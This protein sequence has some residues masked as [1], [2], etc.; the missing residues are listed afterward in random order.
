M[1]HVR[2]YKVF[3]DIGKFSTVPDGFKNICVHMVYDVKHDGRHRARLVANGQL[4]DISIDSVHS[5]EYRKL[6]KI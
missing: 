5:G 1:E 2:G 4:A 3:K 6:R